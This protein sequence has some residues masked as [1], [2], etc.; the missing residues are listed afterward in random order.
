MT[1][2]A[3]SLLEADVHQ[4]FRY[5][6]LLFIVAPMLLVHAIASRSGMRRTAQWVMAAALTAAIAFGVLRNVP[7]WSWLAPTTLGT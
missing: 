6:P 1:R 3:I 2:A 7:A 4:A 5:N